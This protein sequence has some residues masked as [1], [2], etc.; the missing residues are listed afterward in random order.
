MNDKLKYAAAF[1]LKQNPFA[2]IQYSNS[3]NTFETFYNV[4]DYMKAVE[5]KNNYIEVKNEEN[6]L[7]GHE[8]ILRQY[9]GYNKS[10]YASVEHGMRIN[11]TYGYYETFGTTLPGILTFGEYRY[12][13]LKD[14]GDKLIFDIGPYIHYAESK[15][16]DFEVHALKQNLGKTLLVFPGHSIEAVS[17]KMNGNYFI[18]KVKEI[19]EN[20]SFDSVVACVYFMDILRGKHL[21]LEKEGFCVVTAGNKWNIDFLNNLKAI[22]NLCDVCV[23]EGLGTNLGY[24]IYCNKPV[25]FID[26]E[27]EEIVVDVSS[28]YASPMREYEMQEKALKEQSKI[29]EKVVELFGTYQ[30]HVTKSQYDWCNQYWGFDKVK[31]PNQLLE[32]FQLLELEKMRSPKKR[33]KFVSNLLQNKTVGVDLKRAYDALRDEQKVNDYYKNKLKYGGYDENC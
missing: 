21:M 31:T 16:S 24:I 27:V 9:A 12:S 30:E 19:K 2:K 6:L 17:N 33:R 4:F 18:Q 5:R 20:Y 11:E 23:I 7:Y 13:V 25:I 28:R 1:F 32:L 15:Y 10:I 22:I 14:R 8:Y 26:S 29:K 3:N